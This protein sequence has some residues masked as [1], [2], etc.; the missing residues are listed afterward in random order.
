[1]GSEK[2]VIYWE[3]LKLKELLDLQTGLGD[4][5]DEDELHFIIIHQIFELWF[6]LMLKELRLIRDKMSSS[7]VEE[8]VLP[9]VV[10]HIKR[11]IIIFELASKQFKL[12]E[13]LTP[14][15]FL[16]FRSKLGTASGFQ[17]FQMREMEILFGL[18][19][20]ERQ[21]VGHSDPLSFILK[22]AE[23]S[24]ER[25]F[26]TS[27]VNSIKKEVTVRTSINNWLYRTPIHGSSPNDKN[28][29][30]IVRDFITRYLDLLKEQNQKQLEELITYGGSVDELKMR[31]DASY[32]S[33][34]LFLNADDIDEDQRERIRRI[35]TSI[36]FIESYRDLPLLAWPR[37]LID[38]IVELEEAFITFRFY[39]ARMVERV[40]GRRVGTGG[41]SGVEYLDSTQKYRIFPELWSVRTL[42]LPKNILPPLQNPEF[43]QF[44]IED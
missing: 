39:H 10:H 3:Y 43:Y 32:N 23:N 6:K 25:D 34:K 28:D 15:D 40:I 27:R 42:L 44:K 14:L 29:D 19:D 21:K 36:L 11:C 38:S 24:K 18:D 41:S 17:S 8:E 37:L 4:S 12:M 2:E 31:F 1:M 33:C 13:T 7:K 22:V 5:I 26:I 16:K 30:V 35:R 20:I 9:Y